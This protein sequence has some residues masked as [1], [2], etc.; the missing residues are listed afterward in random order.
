MYMQYAPEVLDLLV[1]PGRCFL[2]TL[3]VSTD[4][5]VVD[6]FDADVACERSD[7]LCAGLLASPCALAVVL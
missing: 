6:C 1:D 4:C 2:L 3:S 7:F 5:C